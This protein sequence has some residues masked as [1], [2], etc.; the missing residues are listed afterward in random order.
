M[1]SLFQRN[2]LGVFFLLKFIDSYPLQKQNLN[3]TES[4]GNFESI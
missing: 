1:A 3:E 2:V 4:F